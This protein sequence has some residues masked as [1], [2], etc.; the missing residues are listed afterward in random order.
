MIKIPLWNIIVEI[1]ANEITQG[2][3]TVDVNI[4][5]VQGQIIICIYNYYLLGKKTKQKSTAIEPNKRVCYE[6]NV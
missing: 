3:V 2:T 6:G 1:L 4:G 5:K